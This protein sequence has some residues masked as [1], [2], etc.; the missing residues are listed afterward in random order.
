MALQSQLFAGDPNLEAAATSDPK[1]IT[2][3]S[4]GAHVGKIQQALNQIDG[5]GL[6]VDSQYGPNTAAAVAEFKRK[7]NIL[8]FAGKIDDIVG[9]K[10]MAALDAELP[11]R[12]G[13]VPP[14]PPTPPGPRPPGPSPGPPA[15]S[16][17]K[18]VTFD[19]LVAPVVLTAVTTDRNKSDLNASDPPQPALTPLQRA[20]LLEVQFLPQFLLENSMKSELGLLAGG[21][22]LDMFNTFKANTQAGREVI[23]TNASQLGQVVLNGSDIRQVHADVMKELDKLL[24]AQFQT[25]RVNINS[26]HALIPGKMQG[27]R[28]TFTNPVGIKTS[29][30]V[31]IKKSAVALQAVIGQAFGGGTIRVTSFDADQATY[32]VTLNYELIDHFGVDNSDVLGPLPHGSQGQKSFWILQHRHKPGFNPFVT[33]VVY[34]FRESGRWAERN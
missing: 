7:R 22:G 1:H 4:R 26:L 15:P 5:A 2:P 24:Q 31:D 33:K 14:G 18:I 34:N 21:L 27:N 28:D 9:I 13:P 12:L 10:T 29:P 32:G 11:K 16:P 25:G 6:T 19:P 8:N 17:T 3:G 23:F 30:V 20:A